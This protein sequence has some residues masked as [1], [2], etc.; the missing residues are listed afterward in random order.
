MIGAI[1][2]ARTG[3]TRLPRKIFLE[4]QGK[5]ILEH[6]VDRV[7]RIKNC[8]KIVLAT[9]NKEQDNALEQV[10]EELN[11]SLFRGSEE[12]VLDR[13]Y[14]AAKKFEIDPIIRITA[15][16]PLL[17][18]EVSSKVVSFYLE[19][20]YDYA[21][22]TRPPTFPDGLDTEIFSFD[23][24]EKS[25][26]EAELLSEKEHVT[27]YIANHPEIFRMGNVIGEQDMSDLR[28]TLDEKKDLILIE[29]IYNELYPKN[30]FFGLKE[31]IE[32][33]KRRPELL[34]INQQIIRNE[35]YLKSL[36][37]DKEYEKTN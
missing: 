35:G 36:Q 19:G 14:Q 32:L 27:A 9:T 1:I 6:V 10:A 20:D 24:L 5:I 4:I 18:P 25:H 16:C 2:Q 26:E 33:F 12:N 31:I 8:R 15:D 3:S 23:A 13:F 28:L 21:S 22:N 29:E 7:K 34:K 30:P 11:L 37:R 17:D